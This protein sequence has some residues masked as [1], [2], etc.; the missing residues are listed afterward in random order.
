M[1]W[2]P[3]PRR[4]PESRWRGRDREFLLLDLKP[5]GPYRAGRGLRVLDPTAYAGLAATRS[6]VGFAA[7]FSSTGWTRF[8]LVVR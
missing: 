1:L 6:L 5:E 3:P 7:G 2:L 4:T 8:P